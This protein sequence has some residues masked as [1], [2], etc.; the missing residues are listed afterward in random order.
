MC[1]PKEYGRLGVK[2]LRL[3]NIALLGKWRIGTKN[4][5]LWRAILESKYDMEKFR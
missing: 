3:F 2:D 5:G 1:K 4:D